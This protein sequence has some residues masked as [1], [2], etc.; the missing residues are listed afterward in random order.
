MNPPL[1]AKSKKVVAFNPT[2]DASF[3][4][5][6]VF[7]NF[8]NLLTYTDSLRALN[9]FLIHCFHGN[10]PN[11]LFVCYFSVLLGWVPFLFDWAEFQ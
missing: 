9:R 5:Q 2:S 1:S 4:S 11:F 8:V 7:L 3:F 6:Y 10:Y